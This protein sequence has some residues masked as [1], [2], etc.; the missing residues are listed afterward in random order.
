MGLF[1]G[2]IKMIFYSLNQIASRRHF[3]DVFP[4][5]NV[6]K[7]IYRDYIKFYNWIVYIQ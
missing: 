4:S 5:P 3:G 6:Q 1:I 7:F 2:Q